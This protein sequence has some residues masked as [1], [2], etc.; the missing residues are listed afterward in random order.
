MQLFNFK[1]NKIKK[2]EESGFVNPEV[3]EVNL[4]K[5][6]MEVNFEW[7]KRM[8]SLFLPLFVAGL[9]IAEIYFGL[10]WW[11]KQE[12]QKAISLKNDYEKVS[13]SVKNIRAQAEEVMI[14]KDKL[15]VSQKMIDNHIYWTNFFSWLEKNTLNSVT[16]SGGFTGDI[17]GEYNFG[18]TT[19][20]YSDISW[21]VKQFRADK[22]VSSVN[23]GSGSASGYSSQSEESGDGQKKTV[24]EP[25]VSF[26][27]ELNVK[28]E[29]FFR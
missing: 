12:E 18:A 13:Q 10:D 26:D 20:N 1:N 4:I 28:P 14:F 27:L 24:S 19:K 2:I 7:N 15:A 21:Q 25:V 5:D 29:I 16:Y 11:Q 17:S 23:V 22:Y 3:L 9:F 6:E 8:L